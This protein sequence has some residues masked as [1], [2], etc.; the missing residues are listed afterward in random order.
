MQKILMPLMATGL[1]FAASQGVAQTLWRDNQVSPDVTGQ[2][3]NAKADNARYVNLQHR[4][5]EQRLLTR[6]KQLNITIPAPDGSNI[7][8][9]LIEDS[10]ME[11][12]LAAKFPDIKSYKAVSETGQ[13]IGRFSF[14]HKGLHG[15]YLY[16]NQWAYLD[17]LFLRNNSQYISYYRKDARRLDKQSFNEDL[18]RM[19]QFQAQQVRTEHDELRAST[20]DT[21][22]TYRLAVSTTGE[23][24]Q[25]HKSD[26]NAEFG[27]VAD[28]IAALNATVTRVNQVYLADVAV[29][30]VLV[31]NNDQ[32]VFTDPES[33]PF[34]N[35]SDDIDL[36]QEVVDN[37]IGT[38]NY[39]V[40][41]VFT[42]SNG[43][44]A[45]LGSV[46]TTSKATGLTGLPAPTGDAFNIDYVS[47]ELGHQFSATHSFNGTESSC[48][49][50]TGASAWEP[51]SGATIMGYATLC[52]GQ[53]LQQY[54]EALFHI[55]S[56]EQ[57]REFIDDGTG[58]TCGTKS[59]ISNTQ[60]T[61]SA[62]A[63]YTI[64]AR[65]PF[66][67]AGEGSDADDDTL[68]YNWEQIDVGAAS[69]SRETMVDDGTRPLFRTWASTSETT[70]Y[71]PRLSDVLAN[72]TTIGETYPTTSRTMN[73]RLTARDG[74]GGLNTD[75]MQLTTVA[76]GSGFQ[77]LQPSSAVSWGAGS[78]AILLWDPSGSAD[79]PVS[80]NTLD[81]DISS[82]G[83]INFTSF[84]S[85]I[86]NDGVT[87]V[88][89]PASLG[90]SYRLKLNC[91]DNVFFAVHQSDFAVAEAQSMTDSDGDGIPDAWE[92]ANGLDPND[93]SDAS[94][95]ADSDGLT[96]LEEY[97]LSTDP[98]NADSDGDG[99]N[100]LLDIIQG[101]LTSY[102]FENDTDITNF[103][104][105]TENS[106]SV[107]EANAFDG[108]KSLVGAD[109]SDDQTTS[110]TY[111]GEF[112]AGDLNF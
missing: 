65:T 78:N 93:A 109:I 111:T 54:S 26:P 49:N 84:A 85:N 16:K 99:L 86:A 92:T 51:G 29:A 27:T 47:H 82:D 40:G 30:F 94:S 87:T 66:K 17:P 88:T 33:D 1:W 91:S 35:N 64:P 83:G 44:V 6:D 10:I 39:D 56:V 4:M 41:H 31:D 12:G 71:F 103:N 96:N 23:F 63:D 76:N 24:T 25:F 112:V 98:N 11:P 60:P 38:D 34:N 42:S 3:I 7:D 70:R 22:T 79:A 5:L 53:D 43:G 69:S 37:A 36:N 13:Q 32:I 97:L 9:R 68:A 67:L 75:G 61:V 80:C 59:S 57:I 105:G 73:F 18:S 48:G 58:A 81:L 46:C 107:T 50:R 15:M 14:S 62:G 89:A 8:I 74:K 100:D 20:G 2:Q 55:G 95:D 19:L 28:G 72:T 21:L 108:T 77:L 102:S 106:W 45:A 110:F 90:T 104:L 52:E 101:D